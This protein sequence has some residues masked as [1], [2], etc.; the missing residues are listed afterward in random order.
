[1][2]TYYLVSTNIKLSAVSTTVDKEKV[3]LCH[4]R[5]RPSTASNHYGETHLVRTPNVICLHS[6]S[7]LRC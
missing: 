5:L 7:F 4:I 3:R 2:L 1:M 6:L